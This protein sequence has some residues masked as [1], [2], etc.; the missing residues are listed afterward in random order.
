[1]RR[2]IDTHVADLLSYILSLT[3][4]RLAVQAYIVRQSW[5]LRSKTGEAGAS[6]PTIYRRGEA[7]DD[8][9]SQRVPTNPRERT[10]WSIA[11]VLSQRAPGRG[12]SARRTPHSWTSA[13]G[14]WVPSRQ[15][16]C[17]CLTTLACISSRRPLW[18]SEAQIHNVTATRSCRSPFFP[19]ETWQGAIPRKFRRNFHERFLL[20]A[21]R[22]SGFVTEGA[23]QC[24]H[25]Q[26]MQVYTPILRGLEQT[27]VRVFI[28]TARKS[29]YTVC[30]A[31]GFPCKKKWQKRFQFRGFEQFIDCIRVVSTS[32]L[33]IPDRCSWY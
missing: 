19:L 28:S 8:T 9:V 26:K 22:R 7:S 6:S 25:L 30:C 15:D 10:P 24:R 27:W 31:E 2:P 33:L 21:S 5:S 18:S 1:M 29:H 17:R 14:H 32:R 11:R 20:A 12:R 3:H 13:S 4:A 16:L 23:I